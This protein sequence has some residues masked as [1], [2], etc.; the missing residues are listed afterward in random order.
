M[1]IRSVFKIFEM[2]KNSIMIFDDIDSV[3]HLTGK[4][5]VTN[6]F[7]IKLDGTSKLTGFV[8]ATVN[9]PSKIHPALINRPER[10]DEAILVRKP[11]VIDEVSEILFLKARELGYVTAKEAKEDELQEGDYKGLIKFTM[12]KNKDPKFN[13]LLKKIVEAGLTQVQV[14]GLVGHCHEYSDEISLKSLTDAFLRTT[15]SINNSMLVSKKGRLIESDEISE[16]GKA[17]LNSSRR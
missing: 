3:P 4:N 8:I 12:D 1:G 9:D 16:E 11:Q 2:F 7:L 10:F 17:N 6:E 14:S 15:D 13:A 5:E